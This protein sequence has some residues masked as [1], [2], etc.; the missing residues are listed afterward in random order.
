MESVPG[1]IWLAGGL[2][3]VLAVLVAALRK[4]REPA[5]FEQPE[6]GRKP[7]AKLVLDKGGE[8]LLEL[9]ADVAPNHVA[10]FI[11]LSEDGFYN[12]LVF[13]RVVPG[14]VVQTGCPKGDGTG[15]PG[16]TLDAEFNER[17]HLSGTL[18]M[19][20]TSDPNSAGSQFYICL[21]PQ[22]ALDRQYTVF[23]QV[24]EGFEHV[25]AIEKGDIIREIKI[26]S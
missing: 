13:H 24:N 21:A 18:A 17:P 7:V 20:R 26:L 4:R 15:G 19:A 5:V 8:V 22:P 2:A 11:K 14:F 10:G 9:F 6:E 23:G 25:Q 12:G 1:W 3:L 16:Y